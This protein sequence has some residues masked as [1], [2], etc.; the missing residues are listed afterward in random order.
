MDIA[1]D[2]LIKLQEIDSEIHNASLYL[3]SLPRLIQNI[4]D[5]IKAGSRSVAEARENLAR[6]QK[7]RRDLEA[8]VKDLKTQIGKYK[9]QLNEVKSNR[10]YQALLKEIEEAQKKVDEIEETIISEMLAAD[11][12]EDNIRD[13]SLRQ[14][15]DEESLTADI[16]VLRAK[17]AEM[18]NRMRQLEQERAGL[19]AQI[20]A[21]QI[22]L[23]TSIF[24]K[25]AGTALSPVKGDFCSLCHMRVRPQ[26][27]NEIRE[28]AAIIFCENC[29]RILYRPE[30][31]E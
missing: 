22:T 21:D 9:R 10:D 31:P 24:K 15:R 11:D 30:K 6:N 29:G 12:I 1:F 19:L 27:L 3:E 26:M 25:R 8:Q 17:Q 20:P 2:T 18:E 28:R 14:S 4:E 16:Q 13:A 7:L 23:Y 5:K